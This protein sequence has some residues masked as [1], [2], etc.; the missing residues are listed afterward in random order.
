MLVET[1]QHSDPSANIYG[2]IQIGN[3]IIVRE[4]E[5]GKGHHLANM[6]QFFGG[7]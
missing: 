5:Y 4:E 3:E 7:G 2:L 6:V 1:L